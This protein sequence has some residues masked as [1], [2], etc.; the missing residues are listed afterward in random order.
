MIELAHLCMVTAFQF[1]QCVPLKNITKITPVIIVVARWYFAC[2]SRER[3]ADAIVNIFS[4]WD[5][6]FFETIPFG[7]CVVML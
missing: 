7:L 5:T 1:Q 2:L 3:M 6:V 4:M